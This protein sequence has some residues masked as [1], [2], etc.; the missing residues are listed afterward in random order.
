VEKADKELFTRAIDDAYLRFHVYKLALI[1]ENATLGFK[2]LSKD[3][4]RLKDFENATY[5]LT[6]KLALKE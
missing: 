4:A 2:V 5:N 6:C 3:K 1:S